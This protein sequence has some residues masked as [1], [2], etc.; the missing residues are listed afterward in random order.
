MNGVD[1]NPE[2]IRLA[3]VTLGTFDFSGK[4]IYSVS[5]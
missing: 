2:L 4:F 3:L 5:F 1:Q